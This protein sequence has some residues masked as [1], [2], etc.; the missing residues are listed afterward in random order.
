MG[1]SRQ[2]YWSGLPL[3]SPEDLPHPGIEPRSPACRQMLYRLSHQGSTVACNNSPEMGPTASG[4]F[5]HTPRPSP[6]CPRRTGCVRPVPQ[7]C[8][9]C[10]PSDLQRAGSSLIKFQGPFFDPLTHRILLL[11]PETLCCLDPLPLVFICSLS[12]SSH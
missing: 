5:T 8:L 7:V 12:V 2:E 10:S 1:F 9:E 3:P 11:P 4:P 6:H